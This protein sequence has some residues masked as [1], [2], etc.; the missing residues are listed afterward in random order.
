MYRTR[1]MQTKAKEILDAA[2]AGEDVRITRNGRIFKVVLVDIEPTEATEVLASTGSGDLLE[3]LVS[4]QQQTNDLLRQLVGHKD[5]VLEDLVKQAKAQP[6][7]VVTTGTVTARVD[8]EPRERKTVVIP[9]GLEEPQPAQVGE[10]SPEELREAHQ[11]NL[12]ITQKGIQNALGTVK[13][14]A[15]EDPESAEAKVMA[16]DAADEDRI[17]FL[18]CVQLDKRPTRNS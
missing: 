13:K 1:E 8:E 11:G 17:E 5:T 14:V 2:E 10:P 6:A 15:R 3:Q 4:G 7:E 12:E 9:E 18:R 16:M